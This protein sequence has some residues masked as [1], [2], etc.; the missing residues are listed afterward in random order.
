[1]RKLRPFLAAVLSLTAVA[2]SHAF[3][4]EDFLATDIANWHHADISKRGA[5]AAQ[6]SDGA[7]ESICWHADYVDSYGYNPLWWAQGA[8]TNPGNPLKRLKA[9]LSAKSELGKVHFDDL[10]T[11]RLAFNPGA[12]LQQLTLDQQKAAQA[13]AAARTNPVA[14]AAAMTTLNQ[15]TIAMAEETSRVATTR[16]PRNAV[17]LQMRRYLSG[18]LDGL[19]FAAETNDV[20][21]AQHLLGVS[22][23]AIQD[24]YSHSNWIDEPSRR[25]STYFDSAT[26]NWTA[27]G[28]LALYTGTYETPTQTGVKSHGK[29]AFPCAVMNQ[30]GIRQVLDVGCGAFSP[31]ASD[32]TCLQFK[33]CKQ[34]KSISGAS[35]LG[36][37]IPNNALFLA[38]PGIN[39]D[40]TWMAEV[41]AKERGIVT[42]QYKPID[43]Y[44]TAES[45]A[46]RA[47]EQWLRRAGAAMEKLGKGAFLAA[48]HDRK[49]RRRLQEPQR[50]GD[51]AVGR[52]QQ[53]RLSVRLG[54]NL[55]AEGERFAG[56]A[57]PPA[58]H[59][60]GQRA[61]RRNRRRH[62]RG[63]RWQA[64]SA[65][66][67][68]G[69]GRVQPKEGDLLQRLRGGR[70]QRL[71]GRPAGSR[72]LVAPHRE[73]LGDRRRGRAR[74]RPVLRQC[75]RGR[76]QG[77]RGRHREFLQDARRLR[78][79][80]RR[81]E[82]AGLEG[83]RATSR[84]SGRARTSRFL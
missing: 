24:F 19:I 42:P 72:A 61:K 40:S 30:P 25:K 4:G 28:N 39:L 5:L 32:P 73:P 29:Y 81:T 17:E 74:G 7:A 54:G 31:I 63:G 10:T 21:M 15:V 80:L 48:G 49:L 59:P 44:R 38:P 33:E 57:L 3:G 20:A 68:A 64:V 65:G 43:A 52:L 37:T 55:S 78:S 79:G 41:G 58:S 76:G 27:M 82:Q 56:A 60:H 62:L 83:I 18:S 9:A 51:R 22:L 23:H 6:F 53:A 16:P 69:Q 75:D 36:V 11:V 12:R 1:M 77:R 2:S 70:R 26:N 84:A 34:G 45:E 71:S 8:A 35:A 50:G 66:Q 46:I 14:M 47:T 67:H 13:I